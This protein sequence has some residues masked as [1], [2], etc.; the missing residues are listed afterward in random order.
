MLRTAGTL[1]NLSLQYWRRHYQGL[2][3]NLCSTKTDKAGNEEFLHIGAAWEIKWRKQQYRG[4]KDNTLVQAERKKDKAES[5]KKCVLAYFIKDQVSQVPHWWVL[6]S[7]EPVIAG[8]KEE[9]QRGYVQYQAKWAC[10]WHWGCDTYSQCQ[11]WVWAEIRSQISM[12][13]KAPLLSWGR[14]TLGFT[15]WWLAA[16]TSWLKLQWSGS[17]LQCFF[18]LV[19]PTCCSGLASCASS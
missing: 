2:C 11:N 9:Q 19:H 13:D 6:L 18:F 4:Q 3:M 10:G 15:Y 7:R 5:E 14:L 8:W 12:E 1:R 17:K 16:K